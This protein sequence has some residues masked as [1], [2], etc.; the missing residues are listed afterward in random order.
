MQSDGIK[1]SIRGVLKVGSCQLGREFVRINQIEEL[2]RNINF[3]I[4]YK[5]CSYLG[6]MPITHIFFIYLQWIGLYLNLYQ[7]EHI[8]T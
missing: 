6:K 4:I 5:L 2:A 3:Q 7:D 8:I 1:N